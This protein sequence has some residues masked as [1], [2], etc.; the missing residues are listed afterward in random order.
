MTTTIE[1][2]GIS[3]EVNHAQKCIRTT[4]NISNSLY[5]F[6]SYKVDG[7]FIVQ[8]RANGPSKCWNKM[9][10]YKSANAAAIAIG[11]AY[12]AG[13]LVGMMAVVLTKRAR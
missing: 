1:I 13:T 7:S 10:S 3:W 2:K 6:E 5:S 9:G 11:T 4:L 12:A 8:F